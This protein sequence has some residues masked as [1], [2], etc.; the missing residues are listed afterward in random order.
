MC[1]CVCVCVCVIDRAAM[2]HFVAYAELNRVC[3]CMLL[4]KKCVNN[5]IRAISHESIT[6]S[7]LFVGCQNAITSNL[8][9]QQN[10]TLIENSKCILLTG[11]N[12]LRLMFSINSVCVS[13]F[14]FVCVLLWIRG[15]YVVSLSLPSSTSFD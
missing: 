4:A 2:N 8:G 12:N 14:L 13:I 10:R 3:F 7:V 5:L 9:G 15:T 6:V 1:V 11:W